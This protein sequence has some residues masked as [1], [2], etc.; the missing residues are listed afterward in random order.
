MFFGG[1]LLVRM[2][3]FFLSLHIRCIWVK[4]ERGRERANVQ[5]SLPLYFQILGASATM[6]GIHMLPFSLGSALV[7]VISGQIVARTGKYRPVIWFG[8]VRI[9][10]F[11]LLDRR[12]VADESEIRVG[13]DDAWVW[14]DD[15]A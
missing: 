13:C 4:Q 5:N 3:F 12:G 6:S 10:L 7:A 15:H 14:T 1:D 8:F 11:R 2:R 9:R